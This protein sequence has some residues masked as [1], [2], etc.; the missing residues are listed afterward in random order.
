MI[1]V[2]EQ[3]LLVFEFGGVGINFLFY[4]DD[5]Y[6]LKCQW[7]ILIKGFFE[8]FLDFGLYDLMV[9]VV[10]LGMDFDI[11]VFWINDQQFL[12]GVL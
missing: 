7:D 8:D 6:M 4:V 9:I 3:L 12:V 5:N 2:K 11:L 10:Q 1:V